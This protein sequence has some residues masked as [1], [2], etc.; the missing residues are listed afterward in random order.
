MAVE[1]NHV[2]VVK[3]LIQRGADV[4]ARDYQALSIWKMARTPE[5]K[6]L[7]QQAGAK[8]ADQPVAS[9]PT[10]VKTNDP[11]LSQARS[12]AMDTPNVAAVKDLLD[13]GMDVNAPLDTGGTT[14]LIMAASRDRKISTATT[15]SGTDRRGREGRANIPSLRR[16][17]ARLTSS[18]RSSSIRMS[19]TACWQAHDRSG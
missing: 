11:I 14:P 18:P 19:R 3:A 13:Q 7:L 5:L 15:T 16:R 17:A 9:K 8:A 12:R 2:E 10:Q 6:N 1:G 4:N